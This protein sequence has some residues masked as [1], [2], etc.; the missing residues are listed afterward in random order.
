MLIQ[1]LLTSRQRAM[2]VFRTLFL[3]ALALLAL[4]SLRFSAETLVGENIY[5]KDFMQEYFLVRAS[6]DH[7]DPYQPFEDLAGYYLG[8]RAQM[9][10]PHPT[11]HPP[12]V[13]VFGLPLGF[14]SYE[15]AA[16]AW[17]FLELAC[18]GLSVYLALGWLGKRPSFLLTAFITL[19]VCAWRPLMEDLSWGQFGTI[20]LILMTGAWQALRARKD[21]L[22]GFLLGCALALKLFAWPVA[23]YLLVRRNWRALGAAAATGL[24]ANLAAGLL[25]GFDRLLLYYTRVS[26]QVTVIYR[27]HE[28]N[29]SLWTVGWRLFD[30]TGSPNLSA[31]SAPALFPSPLLARLVWVGLP[32]AALLVGLW[33]ACRVRDFDSAF[34]ILVGLSIVDSPVVWIHYFILAAI[35]LLV[36]GRRLAQLDFPQGKSL[37]AFAMALLITYPR[38]YIVPWMQRFQLAPGTSQV[39]QVSFWT[40]LVTLIPT[41]L[42][43]GIT[44]LV[45]RLDTTAPARDE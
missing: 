20:L 14:L 19:L 3:I 30:G 23:I 31:I 29:F 24:A 37:A 44:W 5:Y 1:N 10:L 11:P 8:G 41:V 34:A 39:L 2:L 25:M 38:Q 13:A 16:R 45:W 43:L 27:A 12:P 35:P 7:L 6:L 17:Y 28:G 21:L 15:T 18:V 40:S 4:A 22:G 36:L 26:A 9:I 42:I 33:M 32:L